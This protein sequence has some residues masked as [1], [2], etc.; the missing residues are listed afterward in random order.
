LATVTRL[1]GGFVR[2]RKKELGVHK[3]LPKFPNWKAPRVTYLSK[4]DTQSRVQSGPLFLGDL[5]ERNVGDLR[6]VHRT[7]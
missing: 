2:W 7:S 4:L 1:T 5:V 6:Q 3:M